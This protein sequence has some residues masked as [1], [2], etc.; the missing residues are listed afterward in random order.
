M[1]ACLICYVQLS[2]LKSMRYEDGGFTAG[3]PVPA[4]VKVER[5]PPLEPDSKSE[6]VL[7]VGGF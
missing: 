6:H 7:K 5:P 2:A 4:A 3:D 1:W